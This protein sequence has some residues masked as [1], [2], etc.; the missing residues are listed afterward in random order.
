MSDLALPFPKSEAA[1]ADEF[2]EQRLDVRSIVGILLRHWKIVVAAPIATVALAVVVLALIPPLYKSSVEILVADPKRQANAVDEKRLSSLDVDAAAIES[3]IQ[4]LRSQSVALRAVDAL[5][6]DKDA[7]FTQPS[8]FA[9]LL[10]RLRLRG[11][12]AGERPRG[13]PSATEAAAASLHERLTVERIE[14]S[15]ALRLSVMSTKPRKAQ[16]IAATVADAYL[17]DEQAARRKAIKNSTSWLG[18][19]LSDLRARVIDTEAKIEKLKAQNGLSD[20]G[21][22]TNLSQQQ[23]SDLNNQLILARAEVAEK[24]ARYE[25]AKAVVA[26][27]GNV[28]A[29]PEVLASPV[30]AQLRAQQ[31]EATRKEADLASRFGPAYPDLITARS[32]IT[33]INKAIGAEVGRVLDNMKNA[34]QVAVQREGSLKSSLAGVTEEHGNSPAVVKLHELE[35]LAA[36]DRKL[37]E[38]FLA[39][40]NGIAERAS[41]NDSGARIITPATLPTA[42]AFPRRNLILAMALAVGGFAGVVLAFLADHLA[43]G[44]KTALQVETVLGTPV[45]GMLFGFRRSPLRRTRSGDLVAAIVEQPAS[46]LA[47]AVR[48]L[49]IGLLLSSGSSEPRTILVTSSVPGE[50][51]TTTALL[52]AA[53]SAMA[54]KKTLLVDCDLRSK[55]ASLAMGAADKPG[56]IEVLEGRAEIDAAIWTDAKTGIAVFAAGAGKKNPADLLSSPRVHEVFARLRD[57]WDCI[58]LDATPLLPV[59]DAALLAELADRTL[60]VVRW[61]DTARTTALEAVRSLGASA[62]R[63]LGVVLNRVDLKRLRSY[64]YGYGHGY[65]YGPAYGKLGKYYE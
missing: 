62:R 18:G 9:A 22:G 47:E 53:S 21:L 57:R 17:D 40:F 41:L 10:R 23:T 16:L 7:E 13:A 8:G 3:E 4:V 6:L 29:I 61:S 11:N 12:G 63:N 48:A 25:Q 32:Q 44:F 1:A 31:A 42:P 45:L 64:G 54:G 37:Y 58:V 14:Y 59:V 52:L 60:F 5:H 39:S 36:S 28:Q 51:K 26:S 33:D 19:R 30:I 56:L 55:S 65:N 34:Y 43:R 15:Y 27:G 20:V 38:S 50:G 46:R 49:R 24:R 35:R 2:G